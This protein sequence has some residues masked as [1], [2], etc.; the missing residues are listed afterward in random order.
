MIDG[1]SHRMRNRKTDEVNGMNRRRIPES[2]DGRIR[3]RREG[4]DMKLME[5]EVCVR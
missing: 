4:I 2:N 5:S 3:V 1:S